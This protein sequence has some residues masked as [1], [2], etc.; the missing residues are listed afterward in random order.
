MQQIRLMCRQATGRISQS[1]YF[2]SFFSQVLLFLQEE[3]EEEHAAAQMNLRPRGAVCSFGCFQSVQIKK[4][5][6]TTSAEPSWTSWGA[7]FE[8]QEACTRCLCGDCLCFFL[9][10]PLRLDLGSDGPRPRTVS[11]TF[12]QS[13]GSQSTGTALHFICCFASFFCCFLVGGRSLNVSLPPRQVRYKGRET[14]SPTLD[15]FHPSQHLETRLWWLF[16]FYLTP[17]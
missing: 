3:E 7:M 15:L 14:N 1:V 2:S 13:Y 9:F 12:T 5:Y 16:I 8:N 17:L 6:K 11:R 10:L 4:F